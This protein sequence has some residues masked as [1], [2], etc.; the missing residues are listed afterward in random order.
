MS[1]NMRSETGDKS[2]ICVSHAVVVRTELVNAEKIM[3]YIG[4]LPGTLLVYQ[5]QSIGRLRIVE[6]STCSNCGKCLNA[7]CPNSKAAIDIKEASK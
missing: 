5:K 4:T 1:E 2:K 7:G 3:D 6:D